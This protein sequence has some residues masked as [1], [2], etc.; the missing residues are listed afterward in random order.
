MTDTI[1]ATKV[2]IKNRFSFLYKQ[3]GS[4]SIQAEASLY[5]FLD[6]SY[7]NYNGGYWHFYELDNGG[8][9]L[10]PDFVFPIGLTIVDN[11]F[12]EFVSADAA[13]IIATLF[14]LSR[15]CLTIKSDDILDKYNLLLDFAGE[16]EEA[17][18]IFSAID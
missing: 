18:K 17:V 1:K 5:Q 12:D 13:G 3:F 4:F 10:A 15:L 2:T 11:C 16:H 14:V 8:F 7:A 6:D 9:Y